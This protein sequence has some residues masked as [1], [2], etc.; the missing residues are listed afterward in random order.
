[1]LQ[2]THGD[3]QIGPFENLHQ[4]VEDSLTI[5]GPGLEIFLKYRLRFADGSKGQLLISHRLIPPKLT[6]KIGENE[7]KSSFG[8]IPSI[9]V[10]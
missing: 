5:V 7:I 2:S 4:L 10:S 6:R 8:F 3:H 1:L 9:F